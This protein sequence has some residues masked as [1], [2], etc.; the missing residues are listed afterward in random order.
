MRTIKDIKQGWDAIDAALGSKR[1]K[2]PFRPPYGKLNMISLMYLL[3]CR[4]PI[5]YWSLDSGD[6]WQRKPDGE[7]M[8][9]LAKNAGGAV[10]L[11]HDFDRSDDSVD[12]L[13]LESARLAL[14]M[15]KETGMHMLT[16]SQLPRVL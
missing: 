11:A 1:R 14:T 12:R 8:T 16:C 15:A 6:T 9:L 5:V 4:V 2:Y 7:R 3:F 13:V 10:W